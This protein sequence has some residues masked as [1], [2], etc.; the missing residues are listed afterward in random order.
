[1]QVIKTFAYLSKSAVLPGCPHGD[2]RG[3][4]HYILRVARRHRRSL[5]QARMRP[6]AA[7]FSVVGSKLQI[8]LANTETS[9]AQTNTIDVLSAIYFTFSAGTT[10][11]PVRPRWEVEVPA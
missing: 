8:T 9:G 11:T 5:S 6:I 7:S 2:P 4:G 1:L 10:L 3:S